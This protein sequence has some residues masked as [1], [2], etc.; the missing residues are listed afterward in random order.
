M[1]DSGSTDTGQALKNPAAI[2]SKWIKEIDAVEK[3]KD[4]RAFERNGEKIIKQYRN[5]EALQLYSNNA[6][7]TTRVMF[8]TLWT[9]TEIMM[10]VL[11]ARM[12]KVVVEREFKDKDPVGRVAA[13]GAERATSYALRMQQDRF[14]YAVKAAVKDRLLP[15]RGNLWIRYTSDFAPQEIDGEIVQIP[16]PGTEKVEILPLNWLDYLESI[17]RNQYEL[18]W[19]CRKA[20]MTRAQLVSRF[21]DVGKL[22]E[23]GDDTDK[24]RKQEEDTEI[25]GQACVYEIWCSETKTVYWISRGY[26]DAPLDMKP[27]PLHL[28][29]FY[30]CPIPLLA[31]TSTDNTYPTPDFKIYERLAD[32]IDYVTKRISS[33]TECLRIVGA[34]AAQYNSDIKDMLKLN[35]GQLWP[36]EQW[37]TFVEKGGFK[38]VIDWLPLEQA[39]NL[40]PTLTAYRDSLITLVFEHI[41]GIPDILR[42]ASDPNETLGAQQQKSHWASVRV[43]EKQQDVQR[44]CREI[45]GK[46]AEILFEPGLFSDQILSEM[47]GVAQFSPEDQA[48]WPDAL[49][50][51]RNDR[52]RTF[53]V[54]IETDS[55]IAQD[56]AEDRA[57]RTEFMG[58]VTQLFGQVANVVQFSPD[59]MKPMLESAL[60]AARAFRAGRSLEGAFEQAIDKLIDQQNQPPPEPPPDYEMQKLQLEGQKL[61]QSGQVEQM[62]MQV[63]QAKLQLGMQELQVDAQDKQAKIQVEIQKL[64]LESQ[65]IMSEEQ[66]TQFDAQLEKFKED[67]K[68]FAEMQRLELEKYE[69]VLSEREKMIEEARLKQ[70]QMIESV[71]L[72]ASREPVA[73]T[74]SMPN[75][76]IVNEDGEKEVE[77]AR[78]AMGTLR[79]RSRKVKRGE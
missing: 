73:A 62:K 68:Q 54:E 55:T 66:R 35:D 69:T 3:S 74:Q 8:N 72:M 2:V 61:Q 23:L 63:E 70:E 44:F 38:G 41:T 43:T 56:E 75:I 11:Y 20:H 48:L 36:I 13:M 71:K 18:R 15:G 33:I 49:A 9:I 77:L 60:F 78:D 7:P 28:K 37:T 50:L 5:A 21:G 76:T 59:L 30:P 65:K 26:K 64:Q 47:A 79:G 6:L 53:R 31:T 58:V 45:V 32:E 67:F 29:D 17:G 1:E 10:P 46:V 16:K 57:A 39:M 24:R 19:R 51:L 14:N 34:T 4:Q 40:L 52:L 12:P 42:G 22:V 27:D 25:L